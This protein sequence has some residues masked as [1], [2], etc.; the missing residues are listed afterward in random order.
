MPTTVIPIP[1]ALRSLQTIPAN[2]ATTETKAGKKAD[3]TIHLY[4]WAK[5]PDGLLGIMLSTRR[6]GSMTR[7]EWTTETFPD[8]RKGA[9]AAWDRTGHLNGCEGY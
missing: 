5:R 1:E 8:T 9:K 4:G 6:P 7:N 3:G 2:P